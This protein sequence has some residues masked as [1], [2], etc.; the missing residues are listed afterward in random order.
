MTT[1][2]QVTISLSPDGSLAAEL[3]GPFAT[4]RKVALKGPPNTSAL[5]AKLRELAQKASRGDTNWGDF[6]RALT[7]ALSDSIG[8]TIHRILQSQEWGH[9]DIGLDGA[10]TDQQVWH[11]EHHSGS[12]AVHGCRFCIAEGRAQ[13]IKGR[14]AKRILLRR[15]GVTV[16]VMKP[17]ASGPQRIGQC[18]ASAADLDL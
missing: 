8:Q 9:F 17:N 1:T 7:D 14:D 11:W 18:Q 3:P 16:R 13:S 6:N 2:P 12:S 5:Q 4:R 10:P 15:D